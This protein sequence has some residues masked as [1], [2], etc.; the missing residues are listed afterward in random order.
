MLVAEDGLAF[1]FETSERSDGKVG[2]N[3]I[4]FKTDY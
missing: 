2:L 1:Q 3:L 4:I